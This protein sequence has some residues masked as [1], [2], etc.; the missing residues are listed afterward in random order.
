MC[1][2]LPVDWLYNHI[3]SVPKW[4]LAPCSVGNPGDPGCRLRDRKL[5][6]GPPEPAHI[7]PYITNKGGWIPGRPRGHFI[8]RKTDRTYTFISRSVTKTVVEVKSH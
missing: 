6:P 5:P 4:K 1:G 2:P 7:L 8:S 3:F